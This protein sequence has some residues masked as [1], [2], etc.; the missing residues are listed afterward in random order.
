MVDSVV[1][2]DGWAQKK[3]LDVTDVN[4]TK[5]N[6]GQ[7]SRISRGGCRRNF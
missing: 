6:T 2:R 5:P 1:A 7:S 3:R 4:A